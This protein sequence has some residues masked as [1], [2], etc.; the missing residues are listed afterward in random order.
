MTQSLE[1]KTKNLGFALDICKTNFVMQINGMDVAFPYLQGNPGLGK[2]ASLCEL[3]SGFNIGEQ[4][5]TAHYLS[6]HFALKPLEETGGIPQFERIN[7]NGKDMLGTEWSFPDIMKQLY[8][9][10]GKCQSENEFVIWLLD[11]MHLCGPTHMALLYE[12][13]TERKLREYNLPK[14]VAIVL[15]GNTSSKTGAKTMFSAIVNRVCLL[16]VHADFEY[17]EQ[18][19]AI[20]QR[21]HPAVRSFL[22]NDLYSQFFHEDEL[23]DS[24]WAS[25]R[26]WSRLAIYMRVREQMEN[27]PIPIDELSYVGEGHIGKNATSEFVAYY[28]IFNKFDIPKILSNIENYSLPDNLAEKYA[29]A[30]ASANYYINNYKNDSLTKG[31]AKLVLKF[32]DTNG[33]LAILSMKEIIAAEKILGVRSIYNKVAMS[34]EKIDSKRFNDL[35][36]EIINI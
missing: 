14:N 19:Y 5:F 16:P 12:L 4:K 11:D 26:S 3:A 17:W 24:A 33:E 8:I 23:V 34:I 2:T 32:S 31:F 30:Y 21:I 18:K 20:P 28:K 22:G 9:L 13:L 36:E 10:S 6:S 27:N 29:L 15:A 1:G 7:I 25:P 35:L